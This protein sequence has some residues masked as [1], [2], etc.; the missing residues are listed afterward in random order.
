MCDYFSNNTI[1]ADADADDKDTTF[2]Q[3]FE[4]YTTLRAT[5]ANIIAAFEKGVIKRSSELPNKAQIRRV[6]PAKKK[7]KSNTN[8][9]TNTNNNSDTQQTTKP[10]QQEKEQDAT[11]Q[12]LDK[13]ITK[14]QQQE[15][16]QHATVQDFDNQITKPQQ[17]ENEQHATVQ[18][19]EKQ[20]AEPQQ[21]EKDQNAT[22]QDLENQTTEPQQQENEQ[23]AT[24][25]DLIPSEERLRS[26]LVKRYKQLEQKDV[27]TDTDLTKI[28]GLMKVAGIDS[29][30][31]KSEEQR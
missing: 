5:P 20:T 31:F 23:D 30:K 16:E 12:D 7:T 3:H 6:T 19:F 4:A 10:Q 26:V 14:P 2:R 21:Q 28:G 29:I 9:S 8:K 13:Q 27:A 15:K 24:V 18:D 25:Q 17:Q 1:Q 22:V 11:V